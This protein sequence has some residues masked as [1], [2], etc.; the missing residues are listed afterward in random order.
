MP[1]PPESHTAGDT[2]NLAAMEH[3]GKGAGEEEPGLGFP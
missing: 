1:C 2:V 3:A